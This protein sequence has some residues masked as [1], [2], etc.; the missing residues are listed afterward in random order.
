MRIML[1]CTSHAPLALIR[2]RAPEGEDTLIE[3]RARIREQIGRLDPEQVIIFGVDHFAG[4]HYA[5][6]PP[7]C[8]GVAAQAVEDLGGFA[9][10][11]KVDEHQAIELLKFLRNSGFDPAVS[12]KMRVDHAVSQPLQLLTGAIDRYP[13]I[14]IF[15]SVLTP[16]L[17]RFERTRKLGEAIGRFVRASGRRTL[18]IGTGG[19]SHHPAHYFPPMDTA[20]P[21]VLSYQMEGPRGGVMDDAAWFARFADMHRAGAQSAADGL[22]TMKDMRM[23][24]DLD[25]RVIQSLSEGD[26]EVFDDWDAEDVQRD[27]GVGML[28][29]H[30]WIAAVAAF[31][32]ARLQSVMESAYLP[33]VEYGTG[34][35]LL[36]SVQP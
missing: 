35:G 10:I 18:L 28:E 9:G 19:L 21:D 20:P 34:Y 16:P 5:A 32:D 11:L 23:N 25:R 36:Y 7:Y 1:A 14:P 3:H 27:A 17:L 2:P 6:M 24:P 22:R 13:T 8:I 4:F 33:A 12:Y 29:L 30:S 15:I 26:T 31:G